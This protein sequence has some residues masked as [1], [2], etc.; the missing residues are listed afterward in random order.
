MNNYSS[1]FLFGEHINALPSHHH[2][3]LQFVSTRKNSDCCVG[4]HNFVLLTLYL[5]SSRTTYLI[6]CQSFVGRAR[7]IIEQQCPEEER[8]RGSSRPRRTLQSYRTQPSRKVPRV[9]YFIIT[10]NFQPWCILEEPL[11]FFWPEST[12]SSAPRHRVEP[13][14][15][16]LVEFPLCKQQSKASKKTSTTPWKACWVTL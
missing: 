11:Y 5:I 16:L 13:V 1:C 14:S 8:K 4:R 15:H 9:A 3:F 2:Q 6:H 7:L 10:Y 12:A